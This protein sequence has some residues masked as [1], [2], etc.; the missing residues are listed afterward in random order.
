MWLCVCVG[1]SVCVSV[2]R[3]VVCEGVV[4]CVCVCVCVWLWVCTS[5]CVCTQ[6]QSTQYD[7]VV[8]MN[9][10][11]QMLERRTDNIEDS[12]ARLQVSC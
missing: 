12:L 10:R 9:A 4:V 3:Q 8:E 11:Q 7:L 6:T 1:V 2:Y 5:L